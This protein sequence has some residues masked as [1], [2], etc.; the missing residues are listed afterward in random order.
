MNYAV[1][2]FIFVTI[3]GCFAIRNECL[4]TGNLGWQM[5]DLRRRLP[6]SL[7]GH[8]LHGWNTNVLTHHSQSIVGRVTRIV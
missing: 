7:P 5:H 2:M 4:Y 8:S 3:V 1:M 6:V